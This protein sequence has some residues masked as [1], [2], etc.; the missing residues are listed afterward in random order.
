MDNKE[1]KKKIIK[2]LTD[3]VMYWG[4]V[5]DD[6]KEP[7]IFKDIDKLVKEINKL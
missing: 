4:D 5:Y 6:G 7:E 3:L 2:K 1:L